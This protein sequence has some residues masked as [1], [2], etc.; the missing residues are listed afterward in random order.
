[1]ESVSRPT[2]TQEQPRDQEELADGEVWNISEDDIDASNQSEG[3]AT[4][5][6]HLTS[7][8]ARH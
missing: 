8:I 7:E 4:A 5:H 6:E 2:F 1:M 3:S